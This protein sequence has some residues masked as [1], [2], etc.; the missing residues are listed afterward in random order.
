VNLNSYIFQA[1]NIIPM[2]NVKFQIVLLIV[3]KNISIAFDCA[4]DVYLLRYDEYPAFK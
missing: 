4:W 2:V 1:Y 3:R